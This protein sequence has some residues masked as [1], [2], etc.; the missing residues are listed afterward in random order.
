[1][2]LSAARGKRGAYLTLNHEQPWTV[3]GA[4]G[5]RDNLIGPNSALAEVYGAAA[6]LV[7][8]NYHWAPL[9]NASV[10]SRE[11]MLP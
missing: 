1:M 11:C 8:R 6:D 3:D 10:I 9:A 7:L 4:A 5:H 2:R